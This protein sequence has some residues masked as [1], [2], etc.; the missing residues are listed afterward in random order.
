MSEHRKEIISLIWRGHNS[1]DVIKHYNP[2]SDRE[3]HAISNE[4]SELRT[5]IE[6]LVADL[7]PI[8]EAVLRE[9]KFTMTQVFD[10]ITEK[11]EGLIPPFDL[12]CLI[13]KAQSKIDGEKQAIQDAVEKAESDARKAAAEKQVAD[14]LAALRAMGAVI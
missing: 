8:I 10:V 7:P 2:I 3:Y 13:S 5:Q 12:E 14:A 9:G 11:G 6:K 4:T 1:I